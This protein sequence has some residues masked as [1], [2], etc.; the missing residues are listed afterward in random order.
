MRRLLIALS[1]NPKVK[2]VAV[3]FPPARQVVDRFVPGE[4]IE[5][6]VA[7]VRTLAASGIHATID[8]LGEYADD[9]AKVESQVDT[10]LALLERLGEEQLTGSAEVSVKASALGQGIDDDLALANARRIAAA[11][12]E[13]GTTMTI[14]AEDH[15]RTD[16]TLALLAAVRQE[17]PDTGGVLQAMLHRTPADCRA[18]ATAG[19]RIRLCKGAYDE[20]ASVAHRR[21]AAISDAFLTCLRILLKGDGYPMIATHDPRLIAAAEGYLDLVDRPRDSYEFQ[22]L[23]GIRTDEQ[24]RLAASGHRVRV[25]VPFGDDWY[26][27]FMRRLAEKPANLALLG[28]ALLSRT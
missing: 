17:Y 26:A 9:R 12:R 3:G 15:T 1:Q 19:S 2:D 16:A 23:Y 14:D 27:Y 4:T 20:P 5:D 21:P 11:A 22:M 6:A 18:L 25:Y 24:Q 8:H 7:A 10:Y 13:V 28:R